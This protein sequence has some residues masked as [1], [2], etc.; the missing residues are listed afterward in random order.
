MGAT[1]DEIGRA[2]R[3]AAS[4]VG[5]RTVAILKANVADWTPESAMRRRS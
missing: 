3:K 4:H 5:F 1:R 2:A